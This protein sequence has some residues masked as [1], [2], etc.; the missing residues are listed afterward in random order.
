MIRKFNYTERKKI[1]REH[2]IITI[3]GS[4]GNH[5]YFDAELIL[6]DYQLP[7][8]ALIFIEAY[9]Q[10]IFMR[11]PFGTVGQYLPPSDRYLTEFDCVDGILFR[12]RITSEDEP[13]GRLIAEADRIPFK[14][15][16]EKEVKKEPLLPVIPENIGDQIYRTDFSDSPILKINSAIN[17]C[18]NFIHQPV[19]ISAI[20]PS[21]LREILTHITIIEKYSNIDD[22]TDWEAKWL[23]FAKLLPGV[24][25]IP[26]ERD[27]NEKKEEWIE[28]VIAIFCRKHKMLNYFEKYWVSEE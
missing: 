18:K 8:N 13:S 17:N 4:D 6:D 21:I 3:K 19:F 28:E 22:D 10:T 20:L 11:F 1:F 24:R 7:S 12:V 23:K 15:T 5:F 14:K 25:D 26:D 16:E 27:E 2:I 9:R